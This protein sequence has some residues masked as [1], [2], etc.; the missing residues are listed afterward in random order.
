MKREAETLCLI[1]IFSLISFIAGIV[2]GPFAMIIFFE[3]IS[4]NREQQAKS[5]FYRTMDELF[6]DTYNTEE[7]PVSPEFMEAFKKYEPQLGKKCHLHIFDGTSGYYECF[8]FFPSGNVFVLQIVSMDDKWKL[9]GF[10]PCDWD[11]VW[12]HAIRTFQN[13]NSVD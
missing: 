11:S 5:F 9:Y 4:P 2:V 1:S 7:S 13:S 10:N 8:A 6:E 3:L 12:S